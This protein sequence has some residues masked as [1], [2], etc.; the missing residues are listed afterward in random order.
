LG[1]S[2]GSFSGD[3]LDSRSIPGRHAFGIYKHLLPE[4]PW[5]KRGFTIGLIT[6]VVFLLFWV[7]VIPGYFA[8]RDD[9]L[10]S[11]GVAKHLVGESSAQYAAFFREHEALTHHIKSIDA[12]TVYHSSRWPQRTG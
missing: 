1:E 10:T 9:V 5:S 12:L 8:W 2:T 4:S 3:V 11:A 7:Y 6:L